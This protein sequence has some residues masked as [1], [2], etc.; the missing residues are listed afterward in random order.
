MKYIVYLC[1]LLTQVAQAQWY[2]ISP[3]GNDKADGLT[4]ETA[5][6]HFKYAFK[7][8]QPGDTLSIQA[9]TYHQDIQT[10]RSGKKT[11]PITL[12]GNHDAVIVGFQKNRVIQIKH[13]YIR[14]AGFTID[15][16]FRSGKKA[17]DY[18]DKLI[19]VQGTKKTSIKGIVL[20]QLQLRNALGECIRLKSGVT[21]SEVSFN[22][23]EHCGLHDYR[24]GR[25]QKNGEAI[26]IGTAPEQVKK[27]E[28]R[29]FSGHNWVHHNQ[30]RVFG[31]E[32]IDIKE[33]ANL[34]R[35]EHNLCLNSLD[36]ASGGISIRSSQNLVQFNLVIGS[37]GAGIR[38]GGDTPQ[39]A[40]NNQIRHNYLRGNH[41]SG[42]KIMAWPQ[43]EICAN[44]IITPDE[45]FQWRGLKDIQV[46]PEE[47][48]HVE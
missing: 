28:K 47:A 44:Q 40:I 21:F 45:V 19:Y 22:H 31:S 6:Q 1:L 36:D 5:W 38:I 25:G 20:S 32:C 11:Q 2:F 12:I 34:N 7:Q 24:F 43:K 29:D 42:L 16:Q 17:V 26:Y 39:D 37:K 41:Y 8:L 9:G 46:N 14:L 10:I 23:I 18:R 48:C 35:I 27:G 13:S 33:G 30:I 3:T 15:G 4:P